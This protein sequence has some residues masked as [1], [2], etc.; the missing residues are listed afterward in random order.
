[1]TVTL[2]QFAE[3]VKFFIVGNKVKW[4]KNTFIFN[5]LELL[6]YTTI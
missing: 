2:T 5:V 4:R 6:R 1:M 3:F